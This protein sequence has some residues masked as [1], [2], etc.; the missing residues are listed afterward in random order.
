MYA[1]LCAEVCG[2]YVIRA[3][4]VRNSYTI[5]RAFASRKPAKIVK[6]S[7]DLH[8]QP[9]FMRDSCVY[10]PVVLCDHALR[11]YTICLKKHIRIIGIK[12]VLKHEDALVR[13]WNKKKE[14]WTLRWS[15]W[16]FSWILITSIGSKSKHPICH[17]N[18][19]QHQLDTKPSYHIGTS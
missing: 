6:F 15:L 17:W 1:C 2:L 4:S 12:I 8:A 7:T 19:Y 18:N 9:N 10:V 16:F 14:K 11:R 3:W 5:H 13:H